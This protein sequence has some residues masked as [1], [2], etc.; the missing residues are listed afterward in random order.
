M[1]Y[2]DRSD[3][4]SGDVLSKD[5]IAAVHADHEIYVNDVPSPYLSK[6]QAAESVSRTRRRHTLIS[7]ILVF[8]LIG[9]MLAGAGWFVWDTIKPPEAKSVPKFNTAPIE[10]KEF[11]DSID[12][13]TIV[14]PIDEQPIITNVSGTIKEVMVEEGGNV[15]E[16]DVLY[17][18]DN[19]TVIDTLQKAQTALDVA[20]ED[21]NRKNETLEEAKKT[22]EK[23]Q[24]KNTSSQSNSSS[25]SSSSSSSTSSSSSSSSSTL[26]TAADARVQAAQ[27]DVDDANARLD[28]VRET[29]DR[30][31]EQ[32]DNLTVHSPITGTLHDINEAFGVGTQI[33]GSEQLAVVS[34]FSAFLIREVI[35]Q[36]RLGQAQEG[37]EARLSFPSITDLSFSAEVTSIEQN[38]V[39]NNEIAIIEIQNPDERIVANMACNVAIVV[40]SIPDSLVIPIEALTPNPEDPSSGE[41]SLLI[42]ASRGI[43]TA[44]PVTVLATSSSEAAI[45]SPNIQEGSSVVLAPP[46]PTAAPDSAAGEF[47]SQSPAPAAPVPAPAPEAAPEEPEG[48]AQPQEEEQPAPENETPPEEQPQQPDQQQPDQQQPV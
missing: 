7:T 1:P 47:T 22:L 36:D 40:Q 15:E 8:L 30:A 34:D 42:D 38:E 17:T 33:G 14:L 5:E 43:K 44:I 32:F 9:A 12:A 21:V 6:R 27:K 45:E 24:G 35:P 25:S 16:G 37:L 26:V 3:N 18:L 19:P 2:T 39:S 41:I 20:Q 48:E 23:Q 4:G 29:F 28:S 11:V 46:A 31:Q 10:R 13:T